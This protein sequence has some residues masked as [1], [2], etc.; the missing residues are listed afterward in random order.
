ME[1]L[2]ATLFRVTV[3]RPDFWIDI[4]QLVIRL[5]KVEQTA[6]PFFI[7]FRELPLLLWSQWSLRNASLSMWSRS[8]LPETFRFAVA[9]VVSQQHIAWL[10]SQ[11]GTCF[12][13]VVFFFWWL[14][15]EV[16]HIVHLIQWNLNSRLCPRGWPDY[17]PAKGITQD[18]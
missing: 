13:G 12:P 15:G 7:V 6:F 2:E 17:R 10:I 1:P 5:S 11:A 3:D 8:E 14:S 9:W 18:L 4:F 16:K